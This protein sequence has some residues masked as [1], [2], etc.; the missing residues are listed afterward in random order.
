M[1]KKIDRDGILQD[2]NNKL[3]MTEIIQKHNISSST[4]YR[5]INS[6]K[7]QESTAEQNNQLETQNE[8]I[9]QSEESSNQSEEIEESK[10]QSDEEDEQ[11]DEEEN[12]NNQFDKN[13]FIQKLNNSISSSSNSEEIERQQPIAIKKIEQQPLQQNSNPI[14]FDTI[15]KVNFS[16]TETDIETIKKKRHLVIILKQYLN[17]FTKE[18]NQIHGGNKQAFEK[19][20]FT[21]NISQLE[22]ILENCRVELNVNRNRSNFKSLVEFSLKGIEQ[23][24]CYSNYDISGVSEELMNDPMFIYDLNIISCELDLSN[25]LNPQTSALIKVAKT[26]YTKYKINS[27]KKKITSLD[28]NTSLIDKLKNLNVEK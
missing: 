7:K 13:K 11:E 1:V 25:Y 16:E 23:I 14:I 17:T 9:E 5:I 2:F 20:L 24:S 18:L 21:L 12:D 6:I 28:N 8:E 10:N 19:R 22:I 4:Y 15:K 26:C 27:I 3:S